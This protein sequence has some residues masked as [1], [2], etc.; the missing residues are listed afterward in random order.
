MNDGTSRKF[1]GTGWQ[2]PIRVNPLGGL[3]FSSGEQKV[4]E[5]IWLI[6][7]TAQGERQML[8]RFGCGIHQYVFAPN[9]DPTRGSINHYIRDA[10]T[11]FEPRIDLQDVQVDSSPDEPNKMLIRVQYRVRS[12]NTSHNVVYPF[13]V[14]E[15][16][17]E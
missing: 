14:K 17:G 13:Y 5:S 11:R 3:S 9:N 15:G 1:L 2:F 10:L 8:S 12:S 16:P 4:Q 6:L 7:S